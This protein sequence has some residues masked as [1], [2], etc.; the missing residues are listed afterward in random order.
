VA[1][2]RDDIGNRLVHLTRGTD[3]ADAA[4]RFLSIVSQQK[5]IGSNKGIRGAHH[6][7]CFS[8]TP[9]SKIASIISTHDISEFR[10]H[11]FGVLLKKEWLYAKGGRPVIYQPETEFELLPTELEYRH[12]I[13]KVRCIDSQRI[14]LRLDI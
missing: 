7:V 1:Q 6:C 10:Y 11:P 13:P 14:P 3:S 4:L 8:E 12:V 2:S 5:L 9:I